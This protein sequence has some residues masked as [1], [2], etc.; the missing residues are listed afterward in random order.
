V[1][2][3]IDLAGCVEALERRSNYPYQ[4]NFVRNLKARMRRKA[5][6]FP[7]DYSLDALRRVWTVRGFD[8]AYTAPH[9][10]FRDAAD[11]Y[12]RAS[13][14]RV[15]DRIG[16]PALIVTAADDPFVPPDPFLDLAISGNPHI[17]VVL[18]KHGGHCA[19]V[20]QPVGDYDGYW[21]ERE[22]VRFISAHVGS[23]LQ[24]GPRSD[25]PSTAAQTPD[26]SLLLRA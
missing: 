5:A 22:V 4:W 6:A 18:T 1:S 16:V 11:Y 23:D 9:H 14:L 15:A 17:T 26:P 21:A 20:E 24:V 3:T 25:A 7:G 12:Y 2:P 19:Y 13:A 10:G 8:E